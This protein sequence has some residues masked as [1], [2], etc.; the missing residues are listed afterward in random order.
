M[1]QSSSQAGPNVPVSA[2]SSFVGARP[3]PALCIGKTFVQYN[4]SQNVGSY[5]WVAVDLTNLNVVQNIVNQDGLHVPPAIQQLLGNT[6]YFLFFIT[7][8]QSTMNLMGGAV[9]AFLQQVGAGPQLARA[10]QLIGQI[11]TS[12]IL[13]FSY[14]LAA[15]FDAN[16]VPGYEAFD[17]QGY[18][19]LTMQ[20][21]PITINGK[22]IYV[23]VNLP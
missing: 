18:S 10:E 1:A 5:W 2:L 14:V 3:Y 11:G 15:T 4:G 21:M 8:W 17:T 20:F 12:A 19:P 13:N 23:P 16:D 22:T 6:Q 7:A 9:Y